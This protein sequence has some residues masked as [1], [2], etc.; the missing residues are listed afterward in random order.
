[1]KQWLFKFINYNGFFI[2]SISVTFSMILSLFHYYHSL[3]GIPPLSRGIVGK[4]R[5]AQ[6]KTTVRSKREFPL[7]VR[8]GPLH[9]V[10]QCCIVLFFRYGLDFEL[11]KGGGVGCVCPTSYSLFIVFHFM[12]IFCLF[13]PI[14]LEAL[15]ISFILLVG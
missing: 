6:S 5:S 3:G 15:P 10:P 11:E 14:F 9:C 7:K 8:R 2:I 12:I 1:M 4:N 13:L